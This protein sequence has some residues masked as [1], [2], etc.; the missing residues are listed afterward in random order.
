MNYYKTFQPPASLAKLIQVIE[1]YAANWKVAENLPAPFI[2]CL[3]NT[4]QCLYFY[5]HDPIRVV[6]APHVEIPVPASSHH[7]TEV[8]TRWT[9]LW[10]RPFDGEGLFPPDRH[11]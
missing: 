8:Q 10:Q 3:G 9:P 11:L 5:V 2:T 1:V 6:P 7:R 4:E